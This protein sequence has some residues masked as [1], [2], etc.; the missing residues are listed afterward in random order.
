MEI[1]WIIEKCLHS[2]T[3]SPKDNNSS[4]GSQN[5]ANVLMMIFI[6]FF[7]LMTLNLVIYHSFLIYYNLTTCVVIFHLL[8]IFLQFI[9]FFFIGEHLSWK[10]ITYLKDKPQKFG[11]PFNL[12]FY[13]NLAILIKGL[14]TKQPFDWK[15]VKVPNEN[16]GKK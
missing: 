5:W 13:R 6:T 3:F 8:R 9:D 11:S 2:M 12:G 15:F 14:Y 4:W 10:K 16:E 7:L 1:I